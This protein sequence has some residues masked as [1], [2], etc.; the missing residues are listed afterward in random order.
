M[1]AQ[2]PSLPGW[3]GA[4]AAVSCAQAPGGLGGLAVLP[5][6][7][8]TAACLSRGHFLTEPV[9][10]RGGTAGGE[11]MESWDSQRLV[12]RPGWGSH[13]DVPSVSSDGAWRPH[14]AHGLA[15]PSSCPHSCSC[16]CCSSAFVRWSL[17]SRSF[18]SGGS[19][20]PLPRQGH[21][22]ARNRPSGAVS[23]TSASV[24]RVSCGEA[25][26]Q[27]GRHDATPVAGPC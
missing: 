22:V 9:L 24:P 6:Q 13:L 14:L 21:S 23:P 25:Q 1:G 18:C 5:T 15:P 10:G 8:E 16:H 7:T 11:W 12:T 17:Q 19:Q 2:A 27:A 26:A 3:G 20:G 4:G